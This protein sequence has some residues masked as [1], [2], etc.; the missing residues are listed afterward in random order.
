MKPGYSAKKKFKSL[1]RA[2][3]QALGKDFLKTSFSAKFF[4]INR[5]C[6]GPEARPS[7]KKP[8]AEGQDRPSAKIFYFF[9][10]NSLPRATGQAL[11]KEPQ[12]FFFGFFSPVFLWC[13][14][15]LF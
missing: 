5:L 9:K 13:Y 2:L 6:R 10:K 7:A 12:Q 8:F 1:P 11:G 14:N 3:D 4:F 15:T